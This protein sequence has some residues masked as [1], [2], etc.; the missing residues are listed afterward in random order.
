MSHKDTAFFRRN[1]VVF[2][3]FQA[4]EISSEGGL[5]LLEKVERKH[6]LI[7]YFSDNIIDTCH[8]SYVRH[9]FYKLLMQRVFLLMQ[10]YED[11]NDSDLLKHDP[12][13]NDVL[14][15][16]P[17]SQPTVS[18]FEIAM[19]KHQVFHLLNLWVN[20]YVSGSKGRKK[21]VSDID[22]KDAET[23]SG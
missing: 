13:L 3:D 23:H 19:D 16:R 22:G 1:K 10:G 12:I 18:S 11:A 6:K 17:G 2:I 14:G 21:V 9:S 4:E 7:K 20:R 8:Q 5:L 15:G